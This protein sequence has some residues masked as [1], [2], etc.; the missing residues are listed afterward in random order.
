[1]FFAVVGAIIEDCNYFV[2][3]KCVG[4]N[5]FYLLGNKPFLVVDGNDDAEFGRLIVVFFVQG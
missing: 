5:A 1:M 4:K 2:V 3:A